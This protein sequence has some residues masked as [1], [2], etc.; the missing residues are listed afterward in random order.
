LTVDRAGKRQHG[1]LIL[2]PKYFFT[3]HNFCT[4]KGTNRKLDMGLMSHYWAWNFYFP[5]KK[6]ML[7]QSFVHIGHG[8]RLEEK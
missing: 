4:G 3:E 1:Q 8:W 2:S 6:A 5:S 7:F